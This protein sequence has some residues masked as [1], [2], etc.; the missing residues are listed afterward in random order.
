VLSLASFLDELFEKVDGVG[1]ADVPE[2]A[3]LG[4]FLGRNAADTNEALET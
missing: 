1:Y 4:T 3:Q 2:S